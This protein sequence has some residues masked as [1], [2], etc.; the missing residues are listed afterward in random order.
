M[1]LSLQIDTANLNATDIADEASFLYTKSPSSTKSPH[2]P[3]DGHPSVDIDRSPSKGKRK[4]RAESRKLLLHILMQ[5]QVRTMPPSV[6]DS[7]TNPESTV[8]SSGAGAIVGT[9]ID[10]MKRKG[11]IAMAS[12]QTTA[13]ED[14]DD[15][16]GHVYST[17]NTYDLMLQ[18]RNVLL[19]SAAQGWKI[20]DDEL[21]EDSKI[22]YLRRIRSTYQDSRSFSYSPVRGSHVLAPELLTQ[23]VSV[24]VSV[25]Q[26]DCRYRT[27]RPRPFRPPN[28]LHVL[29]LDVAQ[30]LLSTQ[31]HNPQIV[32]QIAYAMIPALST[33]P[34]EMHEKLLKFFE[35][36]ILWGPIQ[37]LHV[38][39]TGSDQDSQIWQNN[40]NIDDNKASVMIHIDQ[41]DDDSL[42]FNPSHRLAVLST[43]APSQPR[44]I[45]HLSLIVPPLLAAIL[46]NVNILDGYEEV[47]IYFAIFWIQFQIL[48]NGIALG[49]IVL[50]QGGRNI[51]HIS[52]MHEFEFHAML[53]RCQALLE[54]D[55]LI[56]SQS[57]CDYHFENRLSRR[58]H[59]LMFD[60]SCLIFIST[61]IRGSHHPA[62]TSQPGSP[63]FLHA[64]NLEASNEHNL[65][66]DSLCNVAPIGHVNQVLALELNIVSEFATRHLLECLAVLGFLQKEDNPNGPLC[67]FGL[68]FGFDSS[69]EVEILISAIEAC[70]SD[71]NL[72]V[73]EV[74]FL[75]LVRRLLPNGM[76][77][78]YTLRRLSKTVIA[79]IL[80]EEVAMESILRDFVANQEGLPG[81]PLDNKSVPWPERP[82]LRPPISSNPN[83][84]DYVTFRRALHSRYAMIWL[85]S[86]HDQDPTLYGETL[87]DACVDFE[88]SESAMDGTLG[89]NRHQNILRCIIKLL[90]ASVVYTAFDDLISRWME[91][92]SKSNIKEAYR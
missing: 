80:N 72:S 91:S 52:Q 84:G 61:I 6:Y 46:E 30:F 2:S 48:A 36:C 43:S 62:H 85:L 76:S 18:L 57:L 63:K 71:E 32:S 1:A 16:T 40:D 26:E 37:G 92:A 31:Q 81:V 78:E 45:Y 17:D 82:T 11:S 86:F 70:L 51:S 66:E 77:S 75:L 44:S 79:W 55:G 21:D 23:C 14:S 3:G 68:P 34:R 8:R 22:T 33:F 89:S 5:L 64:E 9:M 60:W 20:F 83:G 25:I 73:N 56:S 65:F 13:E 74:G 42:K 35:E 58:E 88:I 50:T 4:T 38:F 29:C 67:I 19:V 15:D 39:Q 47:A 12:S 41:V 53:Q 10:A 69:V 49:S 54:A 90:Q 27:A 24:L 87:Y 28:A 7:Y 59:N